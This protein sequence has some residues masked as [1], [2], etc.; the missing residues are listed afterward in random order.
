M[1]YM[2]MCIR[3]FVHIYAHIYTYIY[4][5]TF[6][7][8]YICTHL[9]I[10]IS[11]CVMWMCVYVNVCI[12]MYVCK[13]VHMYVCIH[14]YTCVH[15]YVHTCVFVYTYVYTYIWAICMPRARNCYSRAAWKLWDGLFGGICK[16][17][18]METYQCVYTLMYGCIWRHIWVYMETYQ[19]MGVY[20]D[21]SMC[22]H[23]CIWRH[24]N[25]YT[26]I[27]T[28]QLWDGLFGDIWDISMCAYTSM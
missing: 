5:H 28:Y 22:I 11:I 1:R 23:G 17:V 13:C 8:T 9:H 2:D 10:H 15:I 7:Y 20:G 3:K 25:V 26:H 14:V 12:Y 24:I 18:H 4:M 6:T 19:C 27:E 21:I 16:W